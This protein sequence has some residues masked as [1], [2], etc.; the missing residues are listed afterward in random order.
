MTDQESID[1][2]SSLIPP[3][4]G[5]S[6]NETRTTPTKVTIVENGHENQD[7]DVPRGCPFFHGDKAPTQRQT[8]KKLVKNPEWQTSVSIASEPVNYHD[9]LQLDKILNAQFPVSQK[10]GTLAHDEHLFIVVHQTYE[11]W[12]KQ[13]IF[14]M[15]S[16]IELLAKPI[17][18]DRCL[19]VVVQR[20]QR[21]NMIWKLLNDQ[22]HILET[23]APT[24]FIDFRGYL[25]TASGFQS[26][27]FRIFENKLGLPDS[28]R[29]KY[30]QLSYNHVFTDEE[31]KES[32]KNST[33]KPTL[34]KLIDAWLERTPGLVS[35]DYNEN[36]NK[37]EYNYLLKEYEKSVHRYL[38]DTYVAPAEAETDEAEKKGLLDEYKKNVDAFATIFDQEKHNKL[39][40]RGERK[41]G[42][43][44]L[45]GAL[46]IWLNRDEPR[47]HL[48]YQL[49]YIL[50][51]LDA[52][53]NRWRC[54]LIKLFKSPY[55]LNYLYLYR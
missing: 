52:L 28:H 19:L 43:K 8:S 40:E 5:V 31:S 21:V 44:A 7:D 55:Q 36:G 32:L 16:V 22:I 4:K 50:T 46:F 10:Y 35:F 51:E 23:M 49:L 20:I 24:D 38:H 18:D 29:I 54:K 33:E 34:L 45:W 27:Q 11:L 25:S 6:L 13:I 15:D 3:V 30:N 1:I 42:H 14:E 26:L 53:I 9:Y 37:V 17:V 48:P 47:F 12:F 2:L 41:L 39:V